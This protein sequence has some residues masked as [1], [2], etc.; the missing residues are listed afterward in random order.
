MREQIIHIYKNMY[1]FCKRECKE[2][3]G[4]EDMQVHEGPILHTLIISG[5]DEGNSSLRCLKRPVS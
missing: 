2:M 3:K 5:L 1:Q 4:T